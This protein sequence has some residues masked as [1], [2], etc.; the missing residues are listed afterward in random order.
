[1]VKKNG[2]DKNEDVGLAL[3]SISSAFGIW[4]A[5]NT[6]PVGMVSF[7]A[8]NPKVAYAG[9]NTG[10]AMILAISAG[11]A[12]LYGKHGYIAAGTSAATGVGLWVW[13]DHLL[14][15]APDPIPGA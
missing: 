6:S 10:L 4:S 13:Y 14:K 11:L 9:M 1:M 5:M 15:T 3:L 8:S 2:M 12:L 7:A